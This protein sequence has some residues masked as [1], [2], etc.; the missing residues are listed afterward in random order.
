M[1]GVDSSQHKWC[2]ESG[3]PCI[4][5]AGVIDSSYR[6]LPASLIK[7]EFPGNNSAGDSPYQRYAESA[8]LHINDEGSRQ[9]N[10]SLRAGSRFSIANNYSCV[11]TGSC[12]HRSQKFDTRTTHL[13]F[14]LNTGCIHRYIEDNFLHLFIY[15]SRILDRWGGG[16]SYSIPP[17]SVS[18]WPHDPVRT[19]EKLFSR[20]K[21]FLAV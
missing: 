12:G 21:S 3:T 2:A 18:Q 16:A 8:A 10:I 13:W 14:F 1:R 11:L 15:F 6:R 20:S 9:I 19:H 7:W 17:L 5:D 4:V